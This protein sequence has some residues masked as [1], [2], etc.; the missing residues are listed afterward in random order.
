MLSMT[1]F[2]KS[3]K[4]NEFFEIEIEVRSVNSR[5]L[6][7]SIRI[8]HL[9]SP[10][11]MII[12]ERIREKI[13]RGKV[14][15]TVNLKRISSSEA[16]NLIDLEKVEGYYNQLKSIK[17][18]LKLEDEIN[19]S[20]LL[21]F[22]DV[23]EPDLG[24]F[25]EKEFAEFIIITL[26][27]AVNALNAMRSKEGIHIQ[28]DMSD[29]TKNIEKLLNEIEAKAKKNVQNEFDRL[30]R[31]IENLVDQDKIDKN[32][33]QTEIAIIADRVDITEECV[34]MRSHIS[35]FE[36]ALNMSG[37]TG[38]KLNFILQE[39]LREAN[40]MNSKTTDIGISHN[41]IKIKEEI[42][43]LREQSQNIE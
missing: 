30:L 1:G 22:S 33:M 20:H 19:L 35:L 31:N 42:E 40:T 14:A 39:M 7:V 43:K 23:F 26:D 2:G 3:R 12:R 38:K 6:D 5:Y 10:F 9:L 24:Q 16:D 8:P 36:D 25:E 28:G 32:R 13:T 11:E 15:V 41:V 4:K 21:N 27:E 29:R 17:N 37:E 18:G 34:R